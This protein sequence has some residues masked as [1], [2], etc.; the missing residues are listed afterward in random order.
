MAEISAM[1]PKLAGTLGT[2]GVSAALGMVSGT[3]AARVLG[4]LR[5]DLAMLPR[6]QLIVTIGVLGVERGDLPAPTAAA[7]SATV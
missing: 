3:I 1:A 4:G 5:G 7:G 2:S 6:P